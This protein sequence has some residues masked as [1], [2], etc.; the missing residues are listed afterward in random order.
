MLPQASLNCWNGPSLNRNGC[1]EIVFLKLVL[2]IPKENQ[3][4]YEQNDDITFP[5]LSPHTHGYLA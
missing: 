1:S 4:S 5:A 2:G 3:V